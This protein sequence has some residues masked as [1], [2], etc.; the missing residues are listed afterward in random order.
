MIINVAVGTDANRNLASAL[1]DPAFGKA[2]QKY[3]DF[4]GTPSFFENAEHRQFAERNMNRELRERFV[5]EYIKHLK[6][7]GFVYSDMRA[8]RTY[9]S[10]LFASRSERGLDFWRK[11]NRIE[12]DGQRTFEF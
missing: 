4:L 9:Y 5:A 11:A 12:P 2:R 1:V 8:V 10:L 7:L 6:S 3:T